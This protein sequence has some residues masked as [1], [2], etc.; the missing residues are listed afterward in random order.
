M[1]ENKLKKNFENHKEEFKNYIKTNYLPTYANDTKFKNGSSM[2]S[3]YTRNK[4]ELLKDET[5]KAIVETQI[6]EKK[7]KFT[8]AENKIKNLEKTFLKELK[9]IPKELDKLN[10]VEKLIF[11]RECFLIK[12]TNKN[13]YNILN[14]TINKEQLSLFKD[15]YY[16]CYATYLEKAKAK[17]KDIFKENININE[18]EKEELEYLSTFCIKA[19]WKP[20]K[21]E[22]LAKRF[23]KT[24]KEIKEKVTKYNY[25]KLYSKIKSNNI[26]TADP[27]K[28]QLHLLN[29]TTPEEISNIKETNLLKDYKNYKKGNESS[30]KNIK[31][32]KGLPEDEI[33]KMIYNI[34]TKSNIYIKETEKKKAIITENMKNEKNEIK[35]KITN[36]K[37][38]KLLKAIK[39]NEFYTITEL[40]KK[41]DIPGNTIEYTINTL[42]ELNNPLYIEIKELLNE[43]INSKITPNKEILEVLNTIKSFIKNEKEFTIVDYQKITDLSVMEFKKMFNRL[44]LSNEDKKVLS[45]F[46]S[47]ITKSSKVPIKQVLSMTISMKD[48]NNNTIPISPEEIKEIINYMEENE[49]P[50]VTQAYNSILKLYINKEIHIHKKN[51]KI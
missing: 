46:L 8:T 36:E 48:K 12:N 33:M 37:G 25:L 20:N 22:E 11:Y 13:N 29:A 4:N 31:N 47:P 21:I 44:D 41:G 43:K 32:I 6:K 3:F 34:Q 2:W 19:E 50:L 26:T 30:W 18:N 17:G 15:L 45:T 23:N 27:T 9:T 49:I 7:E 51:R 14:I 35:L 40:C 24:P 1:K 5:I 28:F 10:E 38:Q 16:N 39:E 42:K